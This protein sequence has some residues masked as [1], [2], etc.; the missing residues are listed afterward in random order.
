MIACL[1]IPYFAA[2]VERRDDDSLTKV[3]LVIGGQPWEAR[4]VYAF[5]PEVAQNGVTPGM[6][7][8][9]AHVLSPHSHFMAA[10]PPHYLNAAGEVTDVL[11]DFTHLVEPEELWQPAFDAQQQGTAAGR[12][13]PA[14]YTLDLES[15][16]LAEALPLTQE[17]GRTVRQ[18]TR[19]VPAIGLA[20]S[21][22][23][24]QVA[25]SLARP[26]HTRPVLPDEEAGFLATRPIHFL[27]LD[28]EMARRLR[29]LGIHTLGQLA[30][31]PPDSLSNQFG[32]ELLPFYYLAQ[33]HTAEVS[34]S[35]L[36][37]VRPA[38]PEKW[39]QATCPF[40]PPLANTV[41]LK[42]A[43]TRLATELAGRLQTNRL[44]GRIIHLTWQTE[45]G[46]QQQQRQ[47]LRQPT[48]DPQRLADALW[49]LLDQAHLEQG[50]AA[51]TVTMTGLTPAVARQLNLLVPARAISQAG[52]TFRH[53]VARYSP[54]CLYQATIT[55]SGHPLPE[56]R[57][58]LQELVP[59]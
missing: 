50:V 17:M 56:R 25:A 23:A 21:K 52:A 31:L 8:R 37:S 45:R 18:Q 24:A 59:V 11:T 30:A 13:L 36:S 14:R 51:V 57:F 6:S 9:L 32:P 22:F 43:L 29:L 12:C 33:G 54:T 10:A 44:E 28:K 47:P 46:I 38:I 39:E 2:V 41:S 15:L 48:A 42:A 4:P 26:S 19:L 1:A 55:D 20:G 27:P 7:L 5:S 40:D 53:V 34:H 35:P 3:P 49:A 16:P 58:Q